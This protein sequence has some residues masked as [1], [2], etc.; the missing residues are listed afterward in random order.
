MFGS[1]LH[2]V[3]YYSESCQ[4]KWLPWKRTLFNKIAFTR[5]RLAR[6]DN[7]LYVLLQYLTHSIY[8]STSE[9]Q[10]GEGG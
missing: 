4:A 10:D 6:A 7:R 5:H 9:S 2:S 3:A 8:N 1:T